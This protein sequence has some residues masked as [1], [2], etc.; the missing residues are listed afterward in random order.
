[1]IEVFKTNIETI[2]DS[3]IV[4]NVLAEKFPKLEINFDL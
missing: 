3:K 1:M 2:D 4:L